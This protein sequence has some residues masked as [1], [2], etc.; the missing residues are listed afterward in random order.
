MHLH[1]VRAARGGGHLL[2]PVSYGILIVVVAVVAAVAGLVLARR[3]ILYVI[4]VLDYPFSG[5]VSVQPD[6]FELV[7]RVIEGDNEP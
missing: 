1:A 3:L 7:L 2:T 4:A 5:G 6:A